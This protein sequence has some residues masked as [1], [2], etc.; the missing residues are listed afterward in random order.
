MFEAAGA[1]PAPPAAREEPLLHIS[2]STCPSEV[3][4]NAL[5]S[6]FQIDVLNHTDRKMPPQEPCCKPAARNWAPLLRSELHR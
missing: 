5:G 1:G 6:W 4:F 3:R 2:T